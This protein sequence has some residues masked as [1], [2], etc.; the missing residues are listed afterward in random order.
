MSKKRKRKGQIRKLK[1]KALSAGLVFGTAYR[2]ES[3]HPTFFRLNISQKDVSVELK[4]FRKALKQSRQQYLR[5]KKKL[6]KAVG[7]EHAAI[8]DAHLLML[9]DPWLLGEIEKGIREKL[10]SPEKAIGHVADNL[11]DV[12]HSLGDPFFRERSSDFEEVVQRLIWNLTEMGV[13]EDP[14]LPDDLILVASEIGLGVLARFPLEKIKGLV[15]TRAGET[16]HVAIIARS[17]QITSVFPRFTALGNVTLA[18]QAQQ[19][20]S[21]RFVKRAKFDQTLR[22]PALEILEKVGLGGR[23]GVVAGMIR[24]LN[25]ISRLIKTSISFVRPEIQCHKITISCVLINR[26][27]DV[28]F[29]VFLLF[30]Q[31]LLPNALPKEARE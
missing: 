4:R 5:D 9:E 18:V 21:F 12:Y 22:E 6:E 8:I 29:R 19:G 15:L 2:V 23:A 24:A 7:K 20:H 31:P 16:S 17:Y 13:G 28:I 3:Q 10:E 11:L 26:K 14:D 25:L 1:G 30:F 27:S